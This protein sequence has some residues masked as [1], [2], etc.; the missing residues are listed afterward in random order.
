MVK[1]FVASHGK[2]VGIWKVRFWAGKRQKEVS[3][4]L[5]HG[6]EAYILAKKWAE[7]GRFNGSPLFTDYAAPFFTNLCPYV[8]RQAATG[9]PLEKSWITVLRTNL[10]KILML[11]LKDKTLLELDTKFLSAYF[12]NK[13]STKAAST[14]ENYKKSL[15]PIFDQAILDGILRTN[16]LDL[17]PTYSKDETKK[18]EE[19]Y[20]P[21][22]QE[23]ETLMMGAYEGWGEKGVVDPYY[24]LTVLALA[25]GARIGELQ[26]LQVKH[27]RY[28]QI[29]CVLKV[30]IEQSMKEN[31][32]EIGFTKNKRER[33]VPVV[34]FVCNV[35]FGL[36]GDAKKPEAFVFRNEK[37]EP[38]RQRQANNNLK[39]AWNKLFKTPVPRHFTFHS[40]RHWFDTKMLRLTNHNQFLVKSLMGHFDKKNMSIN[41]KART[42]EEFEEAIP[43]LYQLLENRIVNEEK[44]QSVMDY[45]AS[46]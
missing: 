36:I 35:I 30:K 46:Q 16:P 11:D 18:G 29:T 21:T 37:G 25:T 7:E 31:L 5:T 10:E 19:K 15:K 40:L 41:Y 6:G 27:L 38:L 26:S 2:K 8:N 22:D 45:L 17:V 32:R 4:G 34:D 12:L 20:V 42:E 3:T 39:S 9:K 13:K 33:W 44:Y 14:I 24:G 23:V 1:V 43:Y 28:N